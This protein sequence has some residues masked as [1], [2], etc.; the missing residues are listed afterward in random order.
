MSDQVLEAYVQRYIAAQS[1][2]EVEFTWQGG[3]PTLM[4]LE[5][6]ERAVALQRKF[7]QGKQI[8]NTLQTNGTLLDDDWGAFLK[9]EGFLVGVSLDGPRA[10]NDVARPDKQGE[11]KLRQHAAWFG[12][13]CRVMALTSTYWLPCPA[14]MSVILWKFTVI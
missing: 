8:R 3:E 4:G 5:F 13:P 2:P 12:G 6:F 11:F 14:P 7:S 1:A 9:R 10:L